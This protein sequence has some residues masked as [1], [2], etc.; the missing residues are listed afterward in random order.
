VAFLMQRMFQR[1]DARAKG[2]MRA[3]SGFTC[4]NSI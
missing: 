1:H 4:P 2:G 3:T